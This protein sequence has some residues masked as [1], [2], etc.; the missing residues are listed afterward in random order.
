VPNDRDSPLPPGAAAPSYPAGT[1]RALVVTDAVRE[2]T[3][4]A[5]Q[6]RLD[7]GSPGS[8]L[9]FEEAA[10]ADL[11]AVCER[12]IP[13]PDRAD[14]IPLAAAIDARLAEGRG[15]GWRYD[16]LPQDGEAHRRGLAGLNETSNIVFGANFR[17]LGG[18]EQDRVLEAIQREQAPGDTWRTLNAARFFEDL[19]AEVVEAYYAHPLA[20]EEIGY[21]GMADAPGWQA[22][23]LDER[24]E[25]EPARNAP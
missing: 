4:R 5:L 13:Q 14:P 1:V 7:G 20:Q 9:F 18:A 6:A 3:R 25:R 12:L 8:P 15:D 17:T 24:D 21:V 22:I 23:G 10:F 11:E 2:P 16:A 19:L